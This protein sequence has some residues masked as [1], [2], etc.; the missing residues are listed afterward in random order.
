LGI[1]EHKVHKSTSLEWPVSL[2]KGL[3]IL[4]VSVISTGIETV[5]SYDRDSVTVKFVSG[6]SFSLFALVLLYIILCP[7]VSAIPG[8]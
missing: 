7:A 4:Y 2:Q 1:F 5:A 3:A 8:H 6:T